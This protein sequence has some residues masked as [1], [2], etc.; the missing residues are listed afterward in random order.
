MLPSDLEHV[1]RTMRKHRPVFAFVKPTQN[2]LKNFGA[3]TKKGLTIWFQS[4]IL[5]NVRREPIT[6]ARAYKE[7]SFYTPFRVLRM[8]ESR[9]KSGR[10][11]RGISGEQSAVFTLTTETVLY[12][13]G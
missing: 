6:P 12:K 13:A 4:F 9:E 1:D 8:A 3:T 7:A 2:F 10:F 5:L 11:W